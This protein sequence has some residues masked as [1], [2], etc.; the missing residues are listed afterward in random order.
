M[1]MMRWMFMRKALPEDGTAPNDLIT[2]SRDSGINF[3][4]NFPD[5]STMPTG[6]YT[7][8]INGE[9]QSNNGIDVIFYVIRESQIP[10]PF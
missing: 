5:E 9:K 7:L 2:L 1:P 3:Q 6:K 10:K 4:Y 8:Y